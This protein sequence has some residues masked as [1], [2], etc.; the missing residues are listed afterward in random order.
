MSP[1][2][3]CIWPATRWA[4]TDPEA[5][6]LLLLHGF[7]G[8]GVGWSELVA[9]L[10]AHGPILAPDLPGHGTCPPPAP[11]A[12]LDQAADALAD[13]LT[14]PC[15][16]VGYSLGGRL[17]LHLATRHPACVGRLVLIG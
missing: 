14:E 8:L 6:P 7:S 15:D 2:T 10:G 12:D 11:D 16:V 1:Q 17:A 5:A 4:A 3:S 13:Q 9:G